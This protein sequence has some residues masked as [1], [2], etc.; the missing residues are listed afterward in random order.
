M[1]HDLKP[2]PA[3]KDSGLPWLG[4][5][6]THWEE[7]RAKYLFREIDERSDAGK[8]ELLSVSH[9]TGVT[10]RSQKN[11]TMFMAESYAGH[12]ICRAGDLIINTMWAWMAAL[13]VAKQVGIVSPSYAVYRPLQ[14]SALV[15]DFVDHLLRTRAY[16][17]EYISRSTGIRPSRLRLYPEKFLDMRIVCPPYEE[18]QHLV[19]Y[20]RA[21]DRLIR[22]YIH[23]K[24]R[25]IELLNEQ[26][27]IIIHRAVARGL[28]PNVRFKPSGIDWL[29][30]VPGHWGVKKLKWLAEFNPSRAESAAYRDRNEPAVFLP[31]ERVSSSGVFDPSEQRSASELW[32]GYTYFRRHDVV[33]AKITPCFENGKGAYLGDLPTEFGFGTTEF[34][35][36]RAKPD[37]LPEFLYLL[38]ALKTFRLLGADA[39][40]GAAGQQRVPV[41]FLKN[42]A[43][44]LPP[45][46][47]QRSV[48]DHIRKGFRLF[49][50]AIDR[51]RREIDL[52]REYRIRLI[53]E[54]V[55]GKVDVRG[56]AAV[57]PEVGEA[58]PLEDMSREGEVE[59]DGDEPEPAEE[60]AGADD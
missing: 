21:K 58:E 25:L 34:I 45:I 37:V 1:T 41:G 23:A 10:P 20:L 40:T 28:D 2:Y 55:T 31:M 54:V 44:P 50:I 42:F 29:G 59:G 3:Y 26:K 19:A 53:A 12:K 33:V 9:M 32:N 57:L 4:E 13:G 17:W 24:R 30:D 16:Q 43:A 46:E 39:M 47:E 7:R 49:D 8:E 60:E 18:Q 5:I 6:P 22:R 35:V 52:L 15:P 27:Q 56:I 51:V 11:V 14:P 38:T 48:V 36:L